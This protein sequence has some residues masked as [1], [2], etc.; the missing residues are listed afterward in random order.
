[1]EEP[2]EETIFE[3]REELMVSPFGG[4]PTLRVAHFLR[5][6]ISIEEQP[7]PT[8]SSPSSPVIPTTAYD[9][10]EPA[11]K[12]QFKG[13]RNQHKKWEAWI[14][15]L[16]PKYQSI[17]K[18]AGTYEA[19]MGSRYF[20]CKH[21]ELVLG[22][23]EKWCPETNTFVFPWGEA[24]I[25][26]EDMMVLGG[27]SVLG[28]SVSCPLLTKEMVDT[29][30]K[31]F[32]ARKTAKKYN[33]PN[34]S[35]ASWLNH[36]MG[37]GSELEHLA[38]L[39]MWLSKFLFPSTTGDILQRRV[40]PI[41]IHLAIGT[42]VALAPAVLSRIYED[43]GLLKLRL[44]DYSTK[45]EKVFQ[46]LNLY[47]PF[48][49]VQ[50]WAWERFP[51]SR[52]NPNHISNGEPRLARWHMLKP[53][54]IENIRLNLD[55]AGECFQWRPYAISVVNWLFPKFYPDKEQWVLV[56]SCL[57]QDL[58]SFARC[59]RVCNLVGLD[60]IQQ[61]LPHRV[62][63]QFGMD[64]DIPTCVPQHYLAAQIELDK[65]NRMTGVAK[66]YVPPRLT[67][68]DVTTQ[69]VEWWNKSKLWAQKD[70]IVHS[71]RKPRNST[72]VPRRDLGNREDDHHVSVPPGFA[73]ESHTIDVMALCSGAENYVLGS[74]DKPNNEENRPQ[75][76]VKCSSV[77]QYQNTSHL[78]SDDGDAGKMDMLG[79]QAVE[80]MVRGKSEIGKPEIVVSDAIENEEGH[81][82]DTIVSNKDNNNEEN[83]KSSRYKMGD[84]ELQAPIS[85]Y[86]GNREDHHHVSDP[87]VMASCGG[88]EDSI[89]GSLDRPNNERNRPQIDDMS[90]SGPQCQNISHLDSDDGGD[91]KMEMLGSPAAE[92]DMLKGK[93]EIGKPE[94]VLISYAIKIEEGHVENT[95]V[96]K[97]D[98]NEE[99]SK[100]TSHK[101]RGLE[102]EARI[103]RLEGMV[104]TLKGERLNRE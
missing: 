11:S 49:L 84:L 66:I 1:M 40:F 82:N 75:L 73:P 95:N 5:P 9:L 91:E 77:P 41:A 4:N 57:D 44:M 16:H 51:L 93:G 86:L 96:S 15:S 70:Q 23:A 99:S 68:S 20:F 94:N 13:W 21:K 85:S 25:T 60:C 56:D 14:Q 53:G 50:L 18:K 33:N 83:C 46:V 34:V 92:E 6:L 65:Y 30:N 104:A 48:H 62:A 37:S 79:P 24:T 102:L 59:L 28:D 87:Q 2:Q 64:Q 54:K 69:Y 47:A 90:S 76:D 80:N 8:L 29:E 55:S 45:L 39:S 98:N 100:F 38:F 52:S 72:R 12:I 78:E 67:K 43:L 10:Q 32:E 58:E 97:K 42:R 74:L 31:L 36:F 17:W 101:M 3:E 88:A 27:F 103:S 19:I 7:L 22:L 89:T 61:Y 71:V 81:L 63:R 26:L 35:H